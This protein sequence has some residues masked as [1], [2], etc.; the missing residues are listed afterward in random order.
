[1]KILYLTL[2]KIDLAS[3]GIYSDLIHALIENEHEI[4]LAQVCEPGSGAVTGLLEEDGVRILRVVVGRLFGVNFITKGITTLKIEP[5]MKAA[6]RKYLS[7]DDFDLVLYATPPITF[8][9]VVGYAKKHFG[10]RA[11]LMLKD[12]FPQNAVDIGLFA[13]KSPIYAY[14]RRK[15]RKLY[16]ISDHIGCMSEGNR[17]YLRAHDPE[18]P[19]EKILLF[20]NTQ[21]VEPLDP[22]RVREPKLPL[23]FVCGGN[24]G[25]PQGIGFL[26]SAIADERMRK[27]PATF[28]FIGNGSETEKVRAAAG[29]L[30]NM[31]FHDF[32]P[33][34]EYGKLLDSC[35]VGLIPLDHRFT[36][37]NYPSRVLGY[38]ACAKPILAV[39]D[40]VTDIRELVEKEAKCGL[41]T[42]S[43]RV[44][45]L[46]G[47]VKRLTDDPGCLRTFGE[48]G[49]KYF[50]EHFDVK[51]S[52]EA[53]AEAMKGKRNDV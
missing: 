13:K 24:F 36:I 12:I 4:T 48:N 16:A 47:C 37:P 2:S 22:A 25:R 46:I 41:W 51:R 43:D 31:E 8:A 44:E 20:P 1:M 30:P 53:I 33:P 17:A 11:F 23:R 52:V 6:I 32:V 19:A 14:F 35:D 10:C 21:R 26:L 38:L 15:E 9:N 28:V 49:R 34:E 39:T 50:E 29:E 3:R 27:L 5:M 18:L 40:T 7:G 45:N 42:S